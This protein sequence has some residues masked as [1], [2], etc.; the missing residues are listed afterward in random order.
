M[1]RWK[2]SL[3]IE[4]FSGFKDKGFKHVQWKITFR[5]FLVVDRFLESTIGDVSMVIDEESLPYPPGNTGLLSS[6][7]I[8]PVR[9]TTRMCFVFFDKQFLLLFFFFSFQSKSEPVFWVNI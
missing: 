7:D 1:Y 2:E 5:N 8:I 3:N 4:I 9:P 6:L